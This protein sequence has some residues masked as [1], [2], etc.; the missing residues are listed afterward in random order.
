MKRVLITAVLTAA[1]LA[2][3]GAVLAQSPAP[4]VS[5][6]VCVSIQAGPNAGAQGDPARYP[7]AL[8]W[9]G[10][11][12]PANAIVSATVVDCPGAAPTASG[13]PPAAPS[14]SC[15]V[16]Y[17]GH[18][19]TI[20]FMGAGAKAMCA[21]YQRANGQWREYTETPPGGVACNGAYEGLFWFVTDSG[22]KNVGNQACDGLNQYVHGGSL[23]IP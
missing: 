8:T 2:P 6:P 22:R 13:A 21:A 14:E 11:A 15:A 17:Q 1:V 23:T 19:A 12:I 3:G 18:D 20:T 9:L 10:I 5:A 16:R 7:D 4:V